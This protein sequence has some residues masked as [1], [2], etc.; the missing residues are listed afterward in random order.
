VQTVT[1]RFADG[2]NVAESAPLAPGLYDA[3]MPGGTAILAV[4][5]SR[6]LV[7]RRPTVRTGTIGAA[8]ALGDAPSLREL[9]WVYALAIAALCAEWLLRR[10]A[11][12]R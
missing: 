6:E 1:L 5:A 7:P 4:N 11:G 3:A 10:R 12:M 8:A 2:A 9:G